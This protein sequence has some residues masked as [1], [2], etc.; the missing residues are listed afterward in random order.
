MCILLV[1][2]ACLNHVQWSNTSRVVILYMYRQCSFQFFTTIIKFQY[3]YVQHCNWCCPETPRHQ[4]TI[5]LHP[6]T[7]NVR[8]LLF[9]VSWLCWALWWLQGWTALMYASNY[10][11]VEMVQVLLAAMDDNNASAQVGLLSGQSSSGLIS[12]E[13]SFVAW[14]A[15]SFLTTLKSCVPESAWR[16]L[17]NDIPI[18]RTLDL[19]KHH[20][21]PSCVKCGKQDWPVLAYVLCVMYYMGSRMM[22]A[23]IEV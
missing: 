5:Y 18:H 3:V 12:H 2:I 10:G 19:H 7:A 17:V 4:S 9:W 1:C 21:V 13:T 20:G 11:H 22:R 6:H 16:V 23:C 15:F 8:E 14:S